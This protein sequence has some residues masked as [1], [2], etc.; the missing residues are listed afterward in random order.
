MS[1]VQQ[2]EPAAVARVPT[3]LPLVPSLLDRLTGSDTDG[4]RQPQRTQTLSQIRNAFRRDLEDLLNSYERCLAVPADL[5]ALDR[6]V[7]DYGIPDLTDVDLSSAP[8]L[9]RFR[10]RLEAVIRRFDPRFRQVRVT[11]ERNPTD[12]DHALRFRIDAEVH[13][14]PSPE[15]LVLHSYLEPATRRISITTGDR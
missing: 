13:V 5:E 7:F 15:P 1:A 9:E 12:T 14:H 3:D 11:I 4:R 8:Q 6:S 10:S 2:R